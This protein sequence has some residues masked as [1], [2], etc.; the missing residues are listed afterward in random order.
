[1]KRALAL[2]AVVL[3]VLAVLRYA[4]DEE[5]RGAADHFLVDYDVPARQPQNAATLPLVPSAD[6]GADIIGDIALADA[7][8][9]V[10]LAGASPDL[11]ARSLR[12]AE[13]VGD[14]LVAARNIALDALATRPG[15]ATHWTILGELVYAEQSRSASDTRHPIPDFGL[16]ETPLLTSI[17][18]FPGNDA[19]IRFVSTTCLENWPDLSDAMRARAV[20]SFRQSLLDPGFA[21]MAFPVLTEAVGVDRAISLLPQEGGALLAAFEALGRSGDITRAATLYQMWESAEWSDRL[22]DLRELE[23]RAGMND[24]ERQRELAAEWLGRHSPADFDTPAGREQELRVLQLAMN[25]RTGSWQ[26]DP[27][28]AAVRFF[29]NRRIHPGSGGTRGIETAPGGAIIATVVNSLSGVPEPIRARARLL[30]GD[31]EGAQAI[32]ERSDSAGSFEW[33]PFLLDMA[34]YRMAQNSLDAARA[35]IDALA[36]AARNECDAVVLRRKLAALDG[37]T[38]NA[39]IPVTLSLPQEAWSSTGSLSLCLDPEAA[40]MRDLTATVD[41]ASPVLVSWGWNDGRHGIL[42]LDAGKTT[43]RI[44]IAGHGGRQVF[45]IRPLTGTP[46]T[47]GA[48][49]VES[50]SR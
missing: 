31:V 41:A 6:L 38:E 47:P 44:S 40:T 35:A 46:I 36:M 17:E 49:V 45:F 48:A 28:A 20:T 43:V 25:D 10:N 50:V 29:L 1:M 30:G 33:T 19:A 37:S 4:Y 5:A 24:V 39:P 14:E 34:S 22:K 23:R 7:F 3:A 9:S 8:G 16:W 2:M 12:A 18:Y 11:R 15:W 21:R 13:R 32:F 42:Q 27:R 26:S